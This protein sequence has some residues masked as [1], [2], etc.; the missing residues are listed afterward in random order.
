M[1]SAR[2]AFTALL[3]L[4][5]GFLLWQTL[6]LGKAARLAPLWVVVPTFGLLLV[7]LVLDL[8]P[9]WAARLPQA[10]ALDTPLASAE[11]GTGHG[12]ERRE[13]ATLA[14][15]AGLAAMIQFV[16]VVLAIPL[17]LFAYLATRSREPW[18]RAAAVAVVA[19]TALRLGFPNRL[20]S[21]LIPD[22]LSLRLPSDW[23]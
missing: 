12:R 10:R 3:C 16:D 2:T 4:G 14:W 17:F 8:C 23:F 18:W 15:L 21:G 13:A 9:R 6:D 11:A 5:A 22:W 20:G 19:F 1:M 7:Q